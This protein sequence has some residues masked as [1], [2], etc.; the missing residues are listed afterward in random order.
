MQNAWKVLWREKGHNFSKT[1]EGDK[2]SETDAPAFVKQLKDRGIIEIN[3]ISKRKAYAPPI[4]KPPP[5]G[6]LWC[7]YCVKY[8][9]FE[10]YAVKVDG[11]VGP[12]RYRCSVC[13]IGA[14]HFW[15]RK[16]NHGRLRQQE[17]ELEIRSAVK[18]STRVRNVR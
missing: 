13:T 15:V 6:F 12:E 3:L 16:Y 2:P 8:R 14:D 11:I 1:F 4:G 10:V 9:E 17:L 5:L 7:P 18:R